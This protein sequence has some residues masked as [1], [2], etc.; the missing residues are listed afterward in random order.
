MSGAFS[1]PMAWAQGGQPPLPSNSIDSHGLNPGLGNAG[2]PSFAGTVNTGPM[3]AAR[4]ANSTRF[5]PS[6][7]SASNV[8]HYNHAD[9]SRNNSERVRNES[10]RLMREREDKTVT[11]Q[12]DAD[13]RIGERLGDETYWRGE[14]Q[15]EL[16][17]NVNF[18][19]QLDTTRKNLEKALAETE[20]PMRVNAE[21]IHHR[22]GRKEIDLVADGVE[23]S[24]MREV[25]KI[26]ACQERMR[27]GLE[28]VNHQLGVNRN[29]RHQL[30]RDLQNKDHG[31]SIDHT[32]HQLQNNSRAINLH[33]GVEKVDN[34]VSIP[35]TWM[36]FSNRNIQDSQA[37]RS[38]TQRLMGEVDGL[39]TTCANEMWS[40]WNNT[41]MSFQQRITETNDTH[42]KLQSHLSK[43]MQEIYDQEKHIEALKQALRD[44]G[45]PLKV[46]QSRL[47]A[48]THRPDVELCR[49]PPHHRLV[50]EVGQL[51]ESI[52]LLNRKLADAE[53]AHQD[54]LA[55]KARLEHDI[56]VKSNS[57]FIDREKC[58][59]MRKSFP[60]VSLATKL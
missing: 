19:H 6:D 27:R 20:G 21:C 3:Q 47:E 5:S 31:I 13:R 33:G 39:I 29:C 59:S 18:T 32:V 48:R 60:V 35:E 37:A 15:T 26:K 34:N 4:A 2:Q 49:D 44:K 1:K 28:Q 38:A 45:P 22:E 8:S 43:T 41:N 42:N 58:I 17:Q 46:A 54:L 25:D 14:L 36:D 40:H 11:T 9:A 55:N 12:R 56:K 24:L 10:V 53:Q 16:E 57:L 52:E 51:Q 7:W 23:H 30:E 50:E